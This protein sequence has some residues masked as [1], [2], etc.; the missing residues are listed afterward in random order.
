MPNAYV[1]NYRPNSNGEAISAFVEM[2]VSA[3]WNYK[4]SGSGVGGGYSDTT[5]VFTPAT[6][7][8]TS[9]SNSGAWARLQD[10]GAG[11]EF[12]FQHNNTGGARIKYS[13]SQKFVLGSPSATAT[14]IAVDERYLKGGGTDASPTYSASNTFWYSSSLADQWGVGGIYNFYGAALSTPPYGFW[15]CG[16][17]V[18]ST[19]G[20]HHTRYASLMMDPVTGA[21]GDPDPVVISIGG[22][23]SWSQT[24]SAVGGGPFEPYSIANGN[25]GVFSRD[26]N[27]PGTW[28][29]SNSTQ[30]S[31]SNQDGN[32]AH[33]TTLKTSAVTI[34]NGAPG[35]I[36]WVAHGLTPNCQ[37][38]FTTDGTLPAG[39]SPYVTYYVTTQ[40]FTVDQFTV[41][42]AADLTTG[43]ATSSAGTGAHTAN[44]QA[45]FY[46]QP[47]GYSMVQ[48][49]TSGTGVAIV[50]HGI[51]AATN[52]FNGKIDTMPML[53][54]RNSAAAYIPGIKG[55]STMC[56][57][58]GNPRYHLLDTLD[59]LSLICVGCV[60]LPW[61]GATQPV[62]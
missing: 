47:A 37:V 25:V 44:G 53:Y 51:N 62:G 46:V 3:G 38:I 7:G 5:K 19:S 18:Y 26:G 31:P 41:G 29:R 13:A 58:T 32:F 2:L 60:Y 35:I 8:S 34:S 12:I 9:W 48:N 22:G 55:W 28:A 6:S 36:S 4:A 49:G 21:P 43:I 54:M 59:N 30:A 42:I 45:F 61:D 14:P 17:N 40:S 56:R 11:R 16:S 50:M 52:P 39:L 15:Y 10:P 1:C 20:G 24:T 57:W 27:V 33:M 23:S